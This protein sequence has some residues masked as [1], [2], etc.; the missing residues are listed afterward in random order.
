LNAGA[1][2]VFVYDGSDW[3]Q[4]AYVKASNTGAGDQFGT[5]VSLS[6]DG[7]TLAVGA[8]LEGSSASGINGSQ[9]DNLAL[10][11]GAVYVFVYDGSDWS[12]QAYVKA[13]NTELSDLFG[14]SVSLSGDGNTLAVGADRER[15]ST[16]G[17]NTVSDNLAQNAGAVYVFVYDGSDWS[18]QAYVK[19]SNTDANDQFGYSVSLSGDGNTLA[20][21]ANWERSST[22][23]INTIPDNL[24]LYAGA[25][26]VFV[27][28]GSDWS[29]QAYVKASNT[30]GGDQFGTSVS[31]SSDGNTLAVGA[32]WEESSASGINGNQA[33]SSARQQGAVYV[34]SRS[35][36]NWSQQA[37]VK[38]SNTVG[39][40]HFGT[41]V[42]LSGDGNTLAV[43][44][45]YGDSVYLY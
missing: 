37:Y 33:D 3:S 24:V 16:S 44:A 17:I 10:N 40:N 43:G 11:A 39:G 34:F 42:S 6:D 1:V 32:S 22:S 20:V 27:Y 30:D 36:S 38:G 25:V 9:A 35:F 5:S 31:L 8:Y 18:Q 29:Q 2:Y 12:Q 15:S 45:L 41:S 19:A 23:G 13:S 26:Y 14:R 21:G 7:N 4:Q 28:N